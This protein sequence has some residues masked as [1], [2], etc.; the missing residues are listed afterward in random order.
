MNRHR[1]KAAGTMSLALALAAVSP[2]CARPAPYGLTSRIES[3]AYLQMPPLGD[4][5]LPLRLSETGAFSDTANLIPSAGLIPYELI[6]AFWSDGADKSRWVA[7][8]RGK[9]AF[10]PTGE[11]SFPA[12]TVFVKTFDLPTDAANP[13]VKR[14]LETRLLVRDSAGGV[15]GAVYKWRKDGSVGRRRTPSADLVLPEPQGLPDLSH[16]TSR[17]RPRRE[18]AA[19]KPLVGVSLRR[20]R[21]SIARVE[22]HRAIYTG[23]QGRGAGQFPNPGF[24]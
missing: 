15:Y 1:W 18:N 13:G 14:R 23:P 10:A 16:R 24:P 7:V 8:P 12:G 22:S 17:R 19:N 4:G 5:K 9:I 2:S 20:H 6:V 11:W 3:K 21:Q